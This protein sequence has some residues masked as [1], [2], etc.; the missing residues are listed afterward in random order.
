MPK[1]LNI[2][3]LFFSYTDLNV[4]NDVTFTVDEGSFVGI[5]GPNGGGKTTLLKLIMGFLQPTNGK[6]E[7]FGQSPQ[8]AR[9]MIGY[10]PQFLRYDKQFPIS[11]LDVVLMGRLSHLPWWGRY[12]NEDV[13]RAYAALEKVGIK[14]LHN[15]A[16]GTL[17]GGQAQ[18]ALIARALVSNPKLLLLDEPTAS[19]DSQA[20]IEIYAI[21][22]ALKNEMTILMVTHDLEVAIEHVQRVICVQNKVIL[23]DPKEVCEHFAFGLYHTPIKIK[24]RTTEPPES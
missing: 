1:A 2:E 14:H 12:R 24:S 23:L 7:I 16:F 18:R 5:I 11:V 9:N 15:R 19:V 13:E 3:H 20:Q 22:R 17:S 10:V 8:Q 21:L 6:I 4:L